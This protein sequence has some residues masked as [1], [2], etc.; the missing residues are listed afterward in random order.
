MNGQHLQAQQPVQTPS[1][2]HPSP[3]ARAAAMPRP[4]QMPAPP[5]VPAA[6]RV[7]LAARRRDETDYIFGYW[8][9]LG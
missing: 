3:D 1:A 5:P 6:E 2:G 7:H 8:S 9:A 4:P